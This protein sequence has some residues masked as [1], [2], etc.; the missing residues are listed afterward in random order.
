MFFVVSYLIHQDFMAH[1]VQYR[2]NMEFI[3]NNN[4]NNNKID[5][6][7]SISLHNF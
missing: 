7:I 6:F 1:I 5:L 4:N 3:K 2:E